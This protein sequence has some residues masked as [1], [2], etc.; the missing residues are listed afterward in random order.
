M[1]T[2]S[3]DERSERMSRVHSKD[4]KPELVVRRMVYRM[5]YRYRLH[6]SDLPGRPDLA[7]IGMKKAIFVHGCF[8]HLHENC[9][10]YRLPK[11]RRG[12]WLPKLNA[13]KERDEANLEALWAM[14]WSTLV[15]WE[16][17]LRDTAALG[18]RIRTFLE[19]DNARS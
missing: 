18:R 12:F 6:R 2:L 14:G 11:S 16:C 13:N 17:E 3:P 5:G 19:G 7:F 8:W 10:I 15:V 1:D 4:T 9:D